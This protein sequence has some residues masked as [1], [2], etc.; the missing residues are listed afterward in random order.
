MFL[1]NSKHGVGAVIR[2]LQSK[3]LFQSLAEPNLIAVNGKEASFLAGG[4][5][6]VSGRAGRRR[7]AARSS[8]MFKEYGVRLHFTPTVLGGDLINLKVKPEVSSLDFTNAIVLD[9]LPAPGADDAPRRNR[10]RAAGRPDV[11]DCRPDE[12]HAEQLD[13]EDSRHRR[14]PGARLL[15][16][17]RAY[18]KNQTELVVMITPTIVRRG[19]TG[20]SPGAAGAGRAVSSGAGQDAAAARALR[21]LA[22][23]SVERSPRRRSGNEPAPAPCRTATK[24]PRRLR[25]RFRATPAAA[26]ACAPRRCRPQ[27]RRAADT[28]R[29][30]ARQADEAEE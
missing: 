6:P 26:G 11:R 19:S 20:V 21:R 12:Q 10:S 22:A 18:Q 5:Y 28:G 24:S 8:I 15:F 4:E 9:G 17:S 25:V 16:K 2:A 7:A 29:V 23:V 3:G 13:S 27:R 30:A 14:Y 1:F